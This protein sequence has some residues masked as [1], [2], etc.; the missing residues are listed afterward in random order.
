MLRNADHD[1]KEYSS[2]I[3]AAID[4]LSRDA[5]KVAVEKRTWEEVR[6]NE[7]QLVRKT[8]D[9]PRYYP[10]E[11][12]DKK[13]QKANELLFNENTKKVFDQNKS[14]DK[15][16][17]ISIID[18]NEEE[19]YI[20]LKEEPKGNILYIEPNTYQLKQQQK[21]LNTLRYRPLPEHFP[22]L[23]LF[24]SPSD[25]CWNVRGE[26]HDIDEWFILK[27]NDKD[28]VDE[29]REFVR[30]ALN[31]PDFSLM[32]GPPGSG[33]TT[34]I[35]EL[36]IQLARQGK[37]VLLCSA[38]HSAIDNVIE[39]IMGRY[40]DTCTK[41]VV[42][43]RISFSQGPVKES[44]RPYLLHNLVKE[45]KEKIKAFL[46]DQQEFEAQKYLHRTIEQDDDLLDRIILD[47]ANLVAG[48]MVGILQHPDIKNS[49][50]GASFD[51]LI[52][53]ESSKVTFQE[54]LIPALHAKRWVLV[55]DVKQL[56]PYAEDDYVAE[57]MR[58]QLPP[59]EQEVAIRLYELK[60]I[61]AD[62]KH[63]SHVKIYFSEKDTK[64]EY[65]ELKSEY[66]GLHIELITNSFSDSDEE[67]ARMN[68][69][70][71]LVCWNS[72]KVKELLGK[73]LFVP[74]VFIN[75]QLKM[76]VGALFRQNYFHK[77]KGKEFNSVFS[78][79]FNSKE[80]DWAA[81][82]SSKL[83]QSFGFRNAGEE[84][85]NIDKEISLLVP[86]KII[87]E[88]Q[89]IKRVAY[90]SILELL[91]SGIGRSEKQRAGRVLSDGLSPDAKGNRFQ[92]LVYQHRMHPEIAR[93]S[94]VNFYTENNNLLPANTVREDRRWRYCTNEPP[95]KWMHNSDQPFIKG[96]ITN[97]TEVSD[98]ESELRR[99][100]D[101][102]KKHPKISP[103]GKSEK[104]EVAVL[105]FY[106][107]QDRELRKMVRKI[108]GL[109]SFS[110]F[111][112]EYADV[113]LYTVDKFQGQE[114]DMVLLGFTKFSK[115]A[116]YNSPNRLN[117][118]LTRARFRLVLFGNVAWFRKNAKLGALKYLAENFDSTLK[119]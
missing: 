101:W 98:M 99:F 114:A 51:V 106:L 55:G 16:N 5:I 84:F 33:K 38:T 70:D 68:G 32:E 75:G 86:K 66:P 15:Q 88:V 65:E 1:I 94:Q 44:V 39:R 18:Q 53:D 112:T 40:S 31:S 76:E 119:Y 7:G 104:H 50:A 63:N 36:I 13:Q 52:V 64:L 54:F 82:L 115:D 3:K 42:P 60:R 24:G 45:Y 100:L 10:I 14:F 74:A 95:V 35:I 27:D 87:H 29:Q 59:G 46:R 6:N 12:N 49:R 110:R 8:F 26:D 48:T 81:L 23:N 116:H 117:V 11:T 108:T 2:F 105:S 71:V 69:A 9:T 103:E 47:S 21:A 109:R 93:T 20:T 96:R 85:A 61:L 58:Q 57:Y 25:R 62:H 91:Q 77:R 80:E 28:G 30:K 102:A 19:N 113:Y 83:N 22:L 111:E 43:V 90:P 34:T 92:S 89:K 37:R 17:A 41:Y 73:H 118:A 67:V 97:R 72:G 56:S 107:D 4:L 79:E 78:Y